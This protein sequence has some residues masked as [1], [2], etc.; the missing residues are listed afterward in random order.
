MK[1]KAKIR[2]QHLQILNEYS[3][4]ATRAN[5]NTYSAKFSWQPRLKMLL[6]PHTPRKTASAFY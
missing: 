6:P 5:P 3:I 4:K 2:A 1:V